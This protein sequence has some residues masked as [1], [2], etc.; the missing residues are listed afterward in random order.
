MD[1]HKDILSVIGNTPLVRL[2]KI[3]NDVRPTVLCK[4][5]FLNPGGSIKDRIGVAMLS[6]AIEDGKIK[7]GGTIVEPSSG[8]TG[9]GLALACIILG[10]QLIVTMPDK[11]SDEK[12]RLLEAYGATVIICPTDRP[13]GH[14]EQYISVAKRICRETPNSFMPNQYENEI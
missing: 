8:N 9:A 5:E 13:P 14:P 10:F 11:M 2:S 1:Y 4:L 3:G 7:K 6:A 12:K